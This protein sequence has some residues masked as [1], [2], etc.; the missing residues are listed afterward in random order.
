MSDRPLKTRPGSK[1][2]Y[3]NGAYNLMSLIIERAQRDPFEAFLDKE[4]F[5]K[6]QLKDTGITLPQGPQGEWLA[7]GYAKIM[8]SWF[9]MTDESTFLDRDL[10]FLQG[11]GSL[12]STVEDLQ[13]WGKALVRHEVINEASLQ[14][15]LSPGLGNYGYGWMTIQLGK[16]PFFWH[17]GAISPL[18]FY[19]E[20]GVPPGRAGAGCIAPL[21]EYGHECHRHES[22]QDDLHPFHQGLPTLDFE[23]L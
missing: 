21:T 9:S 5:Q 18:G 11:A 7:K 3:S 14:K 16:T 4:L 17:A 10:S 2:E 22:H 12:Y 13:R 6:A 1:Y 20:N 8:G 23:A 15:M 19:S